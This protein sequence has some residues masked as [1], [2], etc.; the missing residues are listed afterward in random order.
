MEQEKNQCNPITHQ[1]EGYW[2]LEVRGH[3]SNQIYSIEKGYYVNGQKD[4]IWTSYRTDGM[5]SS[6]INYKNGIRVGK[7]TKWHAIPQMPESISS[8]GQYDDNGCFTGICKW[9]FF[10][11]KPRLIYTYKNDKLQGLQTVF[12]EIGQITMEA[13]AIT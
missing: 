1:K 9:F 13:I 3:S 12:N 2:E 8:S 10:S 6:K 11:G 7:F 5:L 4:G